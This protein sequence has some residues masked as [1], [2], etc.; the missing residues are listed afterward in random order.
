MPPFRLLI[1]SSL[2]ALPEQ[3]LDFLPWLEL[4]LC[5]E[6]GGGRHQVFEVSFQILTSL[7]LLTVAAG[8]G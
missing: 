1:P 7:C 8:E 4:G 5:G 6:M 3:E 2:A